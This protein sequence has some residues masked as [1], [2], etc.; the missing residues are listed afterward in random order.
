VGTDPGGYLNQLDFEDFGQGADG[1][2]FLNNVVK[3]CGGHNCLEVHEDSGPVVVQ[4]NVV[5]PGCVHGC[6]DTKGVGTP[7]APATIASNTATCGASQ[8]LCGEPPNT[9]NPSPAFYFENP[10][11]PKAAINYSLNLAYDSGVGFQIMGGGCAAGHSPCS[12]AV[13]MYN[14]TVY[15][16]ADAFAIYSDGGNVTTID[17]RNNILDGGAT[18]MSNV[19]MSAEDYNDVGGSQGSSGFTIN[20]SSATGGSDKLNMNPMYVDSGSTPPDMHLQTASPLINAGQKG[21]TSNPNIG[22]Y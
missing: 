21:L 14:N 13:T 19:S 9:S 12:N 18:S 22:A 15:V 8:N 7:S 1:V 16:P 6:I 20:G 4:G 10:Y 5:G 11:T 3:W 17:A 2:Q